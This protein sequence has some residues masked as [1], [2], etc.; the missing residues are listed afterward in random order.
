MPSS[1]TTMHVWHTHA[2]NPIP[3]TPHPTP[4]PAF[5]VVYSSYS[6]LVGNIVYYSTNSFL[7][8]LTFCSLFLILSRSLFFLSFKEK[9][10]GQVFV[11]PF[12]FLSP[13]FSSLTFYDSWL[14]LLFVENMFPLAFHS[15]FLLL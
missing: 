12:L 1:G 4:T 2:H 14:D 8:C 11:C 13:T 10:K 15:V 7:F 3:Q 9:L 6:F 5:Y